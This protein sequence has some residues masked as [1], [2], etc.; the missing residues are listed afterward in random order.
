M[1]LSGFVKAPVF[2]DTE[3]RVGGALFVGI[4]ASGGAG[5]DFQ[6]EV[7]RLALFGY[8]VGVAFL[9]SDRIDVEGHQEVGVEDA[10]HVGSFRRGHEGDVAFGGYDGSLGLAEA[11]GQVVGVPGVGQL[12]GG[13]HLLVRRFGRVREPEVGRRFRR[14]GSGHA[15]TL[16][17]GSAK[18]WAME[19]IIPVS[20]LTVAGAPSAGEHPHVVVGVPHGRNIYLRR[21][22]SHV[23]PMAGAQVVD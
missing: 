22:G 16:R 17:G 23:A 2:G 21:E 15:E 3:L 5:S 4:R 11:E 9:K 8:H 13:G 7:G 1:V 20:G 12:F 6:H 10:G 19:R 18:R 14:F